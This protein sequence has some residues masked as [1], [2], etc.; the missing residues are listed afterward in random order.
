MT[1][2]DVGACGTIAENLIYNCSLVIGD[3]SWHLSIYI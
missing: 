3:A 2:K 1:E